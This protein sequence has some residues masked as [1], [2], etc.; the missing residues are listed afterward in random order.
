[1]FNIKQFKI[2]EATD[3]LDFT[4]ETVILCANTLCST[5]RTF[6]TV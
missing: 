1:M 5:T 6:C 4:D 3:I 2:F